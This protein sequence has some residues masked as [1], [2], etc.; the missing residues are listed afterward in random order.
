MSASGGVEVVM[1]EIVKFFWSVVEVKKRVKLK[2]CV[3]GS[4]RVRGGTGNLPSPETSSA[5]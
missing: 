5:I 4:V 3:K 1:F 2:T